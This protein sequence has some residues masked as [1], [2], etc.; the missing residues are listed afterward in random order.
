MNGLQPAYFLDAAK[1]EA[2]RIGNHSL[3]YLNLQSGYRLPSEQ[4][5]EKAARADRY[6]DAQ[7]TK[8]YRYP[9]GND[10]ILESLANFNNSQD[11]TAAVG[12]FPPND[13]GLY[14]M[15]GNVWEW[16]VNITSTGSTI[17][18]NY[19]G[20]AFT[21]IAEQCTVVST[22][23]GDNA[24]ARTNAGGTI[25]FRTVLP[26]SQTLPDTPVLSSIV[27][28]IDGNQ[29][30]LV[31]NPAEDVL[32]VAIEETL[33]P[34][35]SATNISGS[36]VWDARNEKIKWGPY[37]DNQSRTLTYTLTPPAGFLGSVV[38]NGLA[39]LDG[40]DWTTEGDDT[41]A[42]EGHT[43]APVG[44]RMINQ[45]PDA[46]DVSLSVQPAN[47]TIAYA[48]E[49]S[50]PSGFSASSISDGGSLDTVNNKVKWGPFFDNT[51]RILTY[52]LMAPEGFGGSVSL[53]GF[54][55]L[56][57]QDFTVVGDFLLTFEE[58]P[59]VNTPP[60]IT[61]IGD[62]N[63]TIAEG[64]SFADPGFIANDKEEGDLTEQV[65]IDGQV[66]V[67]IPG[68]YTLNYSVTDQEGLS[69]SALRTVQ[70]IASKLTILS[71]PITNETNGNKYYLLS[72]ASW[73]ESEAFARELGGH[74]TTIRNADE[75]EW[76]W[77]TFSAFG[78]EERSLW[79]GL[80]DQDQEG[81]YLWASGEAVGYT[82]W[83]DGQPDD[84]PSSGGEDYV[85][86][87]R[88]GNAFNAAPGFWNDLAD[89]DAVFD[90]FSPIHGVVE[91]VT[92]DTVPPSEPESVRLSLLSPTAENSF[93]RL[94]WESQVGVSY[95]I[96][97]VDELGQVWSRAEPEPVVAISDMTEWALELSGQSRFFRVIAEST[98]GEMPGENAIEVAL[99]SFPK[100]G[101]FAIPRLAVISVDLPEPQLI[102][103]DS[104]RIKIG[105]L[106]T[107][108][109]GDA[110]IQYDQGNLTFDPSLAG[111][112]GDP[113]SLVEANVF[114]SDLEG[115]QYTYD[116][117]FRIQKQTILSGDV[118]V[119]G[120]PQAQ[121]QGQTLN[122]RQLAIY[123]DL[124]VTPSAFAIRQQTGNAPWSLDEVKDDSL[125]FSFQGDTPPNFQVG[126]YLANLTPAKKDE[127][128]YRKVAVVLQDVPEDQK[129]TVF[130]EDVGLLEIFVQASMLS[131]PVGL[132][133]AAYAIAQE[134]FLVNASQGYLLES[135]IVETWSPEEG[136]D[137]TLSGNISIEP[138]LS[139]SLDIQGSTVEDFYLRQEGKMTTE[140]GA[141]L[142]V[143]E[144]HQWE[145]ATEDPI[146]S[147]DRVFYLGQ[148]GVVPIWL[149]LEF[150]VNAEAEASY[151]AAGEIST[152]IQK[153][154]DYWSEL[155][156][157]ERNPSL[158]G[159][160]SSP[161]STELEVKPLEVTV[162]G[163]A[164]AAVR[165][166]PELT[167]ELES[168]FGVRVDLTPE[169][170]LEGDV[171]FV[172]GEMESASVELYG[173][174]DLNAG[175]SIEGID[176]ELLPEIEPVEL[177]YFPWRF[178]YEEPSVS[179]VTQPQSQSVVA[180]SSVEL[181]VEVASDDGIQYQWYHDGEP[182]VGETGA[183]LLIDVF[184]AGLDEGTY[185][186]SLEKGGN[187]VESEEATLSAIIEKVP[188]RFVERPDRW[189]YG[190]PVR[191]LQGD[192]AELVYIIS[193]PDN[194]DITYEWFK[195]DVLLATND[196]TL[197]LTSVSQLD[198]AEYRIRV[199]RGAEWIGHSTWV[200][201]D[202]EVC[203]L[204]FAE[205]VEDVIASRFG[206]TQ[207]SVRTNASIG[208]TYE[209]E[210]NGVKL[211][212]TGNNL[213][214]P[215]G[216]FVKDEHL[217]NYTVT[218]VRGEERV[219]A[220][221]RIDFAN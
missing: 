26:G 41:L 77:E 163:H 92:D 160:F 131:H 196:N 87:I 125:I 123:E 221:F 113:E 171:S 219:S 128:F 13:Y 3:V 106:G 16:C 2:Y 168:L 173:R 210:H 110:A 81:S 187:T 66:D 172:N 158:S 180:G 111:A 32:V 105:A 164:K 201:V 188:L 148:V 208:V 73:T 116:W 72:A 10:S 91:V 70:V 36:G 120:S 206:L 175:L 24:P 217:G 51:S 7:K 134:G 89:T 9:W 157:S 203:P 55:S 94:I 178:D 37:F 101:D 59:V 109:I 28:S 54:V 12:S 144:S 99:E 90:Q 214:P 108:H 68:S 135:P 151:E 4:E 156:Y 86:I 146:F 48:V 25:G 152:G 79:I 27:R 50:I 76:I 117:S 63:M 40:M 155:V 182:L 71:G 130:T 184:D 127:I 218:A 169:V 186:V 30:T 75:Q 150:E 23:H 103:P 139:L 98:L 97:A 60:T 82:H 170:G 190:V 149:D 58:P 1:T 145:T 181:S 118:F 8:G 205:P 191:L 44:E 83:L 56:D 126:Q 21:E 194:P 153:T 215:G 96:E 199:T 140:L 67:T 185:F 80:N 195:N 22:P 84:N 132:P 34:M 31:L 53:T 211:R 64:T 112:L 216:I 69:A 35:F 33:P 57:G 78:G 38:L 85:H 19:R 154:Y 137:L 46:V 20:G 88:R 133:A 74:L 183:T 121:F 220:D 162:D 6:A 15:S 65:K 102:V 5:W 167:M 52:T 93:Y 193:D 197:K 29:I 189:L 104:I 61:L 124:G 213:F 43:S 47:D 198:E 202:C 136:V 138:K 177:V 119:L 62:A 142:K 159:I 174:L 18:R 143:T 141:S 115:N 100:N 212:A 209:W 179:I 200:I 49:E 147:A 11:T 114:Y 95:V 176:D 192:N 45:S 42:F 17:E 129:V 14:D 39:S 161:P 204:A 165:L 207:V 122:P 107:F 166:V